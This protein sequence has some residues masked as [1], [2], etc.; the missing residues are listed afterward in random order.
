MRSPEH[1]RPAPLTQ[2]T[3]P[4]RALALRRFHLLRAHLEDGVPLTHVARAHGLKHRTVQ[5]W[6]AGYR[7]SGLAGLV[8]RTRS[9]AGTQR[10]PAELKQLIEGLALQRP[11]PSAAAIQRRVVAVAHERGWPEPSYSRVY[12]IIRRLDPALVTLA[13]EGL[14][15]YRE[16]FDLLYRREATRPNEIWQADHTLLDLWV[17]DE[18][19]QPARPWLT[20]ILDDYS[21]A[22]AGYSLNLTAPSALQTALALRQAIWRKSEPRWHICGIPETFYTDQG[23]DFT[24]QHLEQVAA[25]LKMVLVFSSVG[26]PRG[27]GRIERFFQTV[28]QLFLSALPGYSPAGTRPEPQLTLAELDARL[29]TFLLEEYHRRR[30]G[31]T[32][33]APQDRWEASGFL[34][35][36]PESLEQLDLLLLTV[37][38]PR[39]V[40]QDGIHFQGLRYLDLTLSAYVGEPVI[41]RYDPADLAEVRVYY[42]DRFLCR[43][44][45]QEL[46]D[47]TTS[48]P[49]IVQARTQC[50]R[51][52]RADLT[53]R[54]KVVD[55]LLA[56]RPESTPAAA[57]ESAVPPDRPRLK[58]YVND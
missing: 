47:R 3:E 19:D 31:E 44:V 55:H 45:C 12:D 7:R 21:R 18:R 30:H 42:R 40:Q 6:V 51:Q 38:K 11:A 26:R 49:E 27:R 32:G 54:T 28:D 20:V 13:H 1:G 4:Q 15:A 23:S 33:Q 52:V 24:S 8:R 22:V 50:R 48:L 37:A 58:R 14:E 17:R 9:D 43:A 56:N 46:A 34:P 16:K 36:L 35:Q 53:A 39:R 41:I 25:D 2:F 57:P 5:R 10:L 29:R